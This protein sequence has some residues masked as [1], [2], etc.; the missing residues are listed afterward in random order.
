VLAIAEMILDPKGQNCMKMY[1]HGSFW[2]LQGTSGAIVP[3][4]VL[5]EDQ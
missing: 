1:P 4:R 5:A 2:T 3:D